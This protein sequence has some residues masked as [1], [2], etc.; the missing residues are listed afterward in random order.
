MAHTQS[1]SFSRKNTL[2]TILVFIVS[3]LKNYIPLHLQK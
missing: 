1:Y 3:I 2:E